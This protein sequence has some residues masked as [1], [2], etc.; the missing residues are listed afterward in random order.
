MKPV[1]AWLKN[2]W[3]ISACCAVVIVVPSVAYVISGQMNSKIKSEQE[4]KANAKMQQVSAA[5]VTYTVP[6]PT[7]GASA[8]T[9]NAEPNRAL[10]QHF[11]ELNEKIKAQSGEVAKRGEDFNKGVGPDAAAVGRSEHK[12]FVPGLFPGAEEAA[13]AQLIAEEGK[14]RWDGRPEEERTR[15]IEARAKNILD[16]KLRE[17]EDALIGKRGREYPYDALLRSVNAG[18]PPDPKQVGTSVADMRAREIEKRLSGR[19]EP[20]PEEMVAVTAKLSE[21]RLNMYRTRAR[22]IGLYCAL[23]NLPNDLRT[24]AIP[25]E[26]IFQLLYSKNPPTAK[27]QLADFFVFQWDY[28]VLSDIFAAIRLANGNADVERAIVKRVIRIGMVD[29][30]GLYTDQRK[31]SNRE[32]GLITD[33]EPTTAGM[34]PFDPRASVTG[35]V[36]S[37]KNVVYDV[38]PVDLDVIVDSARLPEFISAISRTNFMTVIDMD[39]FDVD[40]QSDL[41]KGYFYGDSHVVRAKLKIETLWLRSWVGTYMPQMVRNRMG[42][43]LPGE[44]AP[45][46][47]PSP[48]RP[49]NRGPG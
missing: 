5:K 19:R 44:S 40:L 11:K 22:E 12:P 1:L 21:L 30:E 28:W 32:A 3:L 36:S 45:A 43:V 31:E 37:E 20:S 26:R 7:P 2:N 47:S 24:R 13:V 9:L 17:M 15:L 29:P 35:R 27:V 4:K 34:A 16:P 18:T 39:L 8:I 14:E 48:R 49:I 41:S 23:P 46:D 38:R 10:T 25:S 33:V 6:V 42:V